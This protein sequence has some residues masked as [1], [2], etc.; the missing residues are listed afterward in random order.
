[1]QIAVIIALL[2][3]QNVNFM[4]FT[5]NSTYLS[6]DLWRFFENVLNL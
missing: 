2:I 5:E 3:M 6:L 1:M 4:N